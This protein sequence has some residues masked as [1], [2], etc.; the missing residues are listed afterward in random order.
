MRRS[1]NEKPARRLDRR[2]SILQEAPVLQPFPARAPCSIDARK[3]QASAVDSGERPLHGLQLLDFC[4]KNIFMI[5]GDVRPSLPL[6][7]VA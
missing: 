4:K 7:R 2:K 6:T 1:R 5:N 3:K